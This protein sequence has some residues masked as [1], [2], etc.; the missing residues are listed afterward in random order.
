M[1][2]SFAERGGWWVVSQSIVMASV[3]ASGP[4]R[5]ADWNSRAGF[6]IGVFFIGAGAV[7]GIAGAWT[8][9]R[10]RTPFPRPVSDAELVEH[11]IYS[12][13]RHPLYASLIYLSIGWALI[14]ANHAAGIAAGVMFVFLDQKARTEEAWLSAEFLGYRTYAERVRRFIPA[15]Y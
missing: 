4:L 10:N 1:K 11:G 6:W 9:G 15:V 8:L 12:I 5:K 13:V 7:F 2:Y 3:L 14:W